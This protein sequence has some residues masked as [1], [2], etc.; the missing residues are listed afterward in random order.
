MHGR[1]AHNTYVPTK[2]AEQNETLRTL[3]TS[4]QRVEEL[5]SMLPGDLAK[6]MRAK[7][8]SLRS[9][10]LEHRPPAFVL[11]GRRGA[12]KSSFVNALFGSKVADLGHVRSE[13]ATGT[14][15]DLSAESGTLAILDTR[16]MQE[17][18]VPEGAEASVTPLASV[19]LEV[20]RRSPDAV[21]FVVKATEVDAA[22]DADLDALEAILDE[23][24]RRHKVRPPLVCVLTHCDALEPKAVKLHLPDGETKDDLDEKMAHVISAERHLEK[25]IRERHGVV[26]TLMGVRGVSTY[27]SFRADG[28]RRA[29][30][31]WRMAD[32]VE[33]LFR[34]MPSSGRG[35]FVRIAQAKGL[36]EELAIDI[37]RTVAA[38]CAGVA[39]VPIPVADLIPITSMQVAL[40]AMIA[41][42]AG[43]PLTT[44]SAGEFLG[45]MGVNVGA[46]FVFREGAR[47]LVKFV[48]PGA[49]SAISGAVAFAGTMGI[50]RGARAYFMRGTSIDEA[51]AAMGE[52]DD[53]DVAS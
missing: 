4:L 44:K 34:Q 12:G 41:W 52:K 30:E 25:K 19:L 42:L 49:G 46:G 53:D 20:R 51:K 16:G 28:T 45:A 15:Y 1:H 13:T 26:A 37:T 36:Q 5:L 11:V 40:I 9:V 32:V 21:V 31:R 50:G 22:I 27:Q 10:V 47:A 43:K 8:A 48:F 7:L 6:D 33:L 23:A 3:S 14:W 39:V 29:D 18:S 17:G 38:L 35:L 2:D 24:E